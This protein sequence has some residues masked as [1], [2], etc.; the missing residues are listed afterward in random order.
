M[1]GGYRIICNRMQVK[2]NSGIIERNWSGDSFYSRIHD[3]LAQL[4]ITCAML[5]K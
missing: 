5:D 1:N 2:S 4:M 3:C